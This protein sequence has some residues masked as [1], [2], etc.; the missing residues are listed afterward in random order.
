M[1]TTTKLFDQYVDRNL[2]DFIAFEF[3][4]FYRGQHHDKI[5]SAIENYFDDSDMEDY[6]YNHEATCMNYAD[7]LLEAIDKELL[8]NFSQCFVKIDSPKYYN[9]STDCIRIDKTKA[10]QN[11]LDLIYKD[12][13]KL[14]ALFDNLNFCNELEFDI[15]L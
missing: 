11:L 15:E 14:Q 8:T 5:E 6:D 9:Y 7:A 3:G 1:E 2:K 4:G 12:D 13:S 10:N